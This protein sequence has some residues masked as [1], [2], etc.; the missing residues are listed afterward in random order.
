ML[1]SFDAQAAEIVSEQL[2]FAVIETVGQH[3]ADLALDFG[4]IAAPNDGNVDDDENCFYVDNNDNDSLAFALDSIVAGDYDVDD[5]ACFE[6][7]FHV[8]CSSSMYNKHI[9]H[10]ILNN[11]SFF[12]K[13]KR[14]D[15]FVECCVIYMRMR[16]KKFK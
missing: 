12:V 8:F 10:S 3:F 5:N 6:I 13:H 2:A 9:S 4:Y 16:K 14:V 11:S 15:P 1:Y 7:I